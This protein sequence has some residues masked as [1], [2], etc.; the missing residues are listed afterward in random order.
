MSV[1]LRSSLIIALCAASASVGQAQDITLFDAEGFEW[2]LDSTGYGYVKDGG[3]T[4]GL[5]D[6]YDSWP[7]VCILTD[8]SDL[9]S[10]GSTEYYFVS[11]DAVQNG[12]EVIM[13]TDTVQ[14]LN[15]HRRAYV[16]DSGI[17]FL[18]YVDV[19][20]NPGAAPITFKV[21]VGTVQTFG[22]LGSDSSTQVT[23][24]SS[25]D[26]MLGTNDTWFTTDDFNT[27]GGDP[28]LGYVMR[29]NG[30]LNGVT[31]V[32]N[33]P[34]WISFSGSDDIVWEYE[35]VVLAPGDTVAYMYF[36]VQQ[37][38][39]ATAQARVSTIATGDPSYW[40]D[41]DPSIR[42]FIRNWALG[43]PALCGNNVVD[44]GEQ[45]DDGN[46][47]PTDAC[48]DFCLNAR[49]RDGRVQAGVEEC[50]DG[51]G[52]NDDA[53]SNMCTL[54]VC[55]DGIEQG[56]EECDLGMMNSD[57]EVDGCRTSCRF[58]FC[59]D[60][61]R[62]TGEGCDDGN[63]DDG[64]M[65]TNECVMATCGDGIVQSGIGEE[66]DDG[67]AFDRDACTAMCRTAVCG[68][69]I[70]RL[71][72]EE[73][74]DGNDVDGDG[75]S[76][77][78]TGSMCGNGRLDS[79]EQCDEGP[80]N[81]NTEP[82]ACRN[83][84]TSARCGDRVVDLGEECDDGNTDDGDSCTSTCSAPACG[85]GIVSTGELCDDGAENGMQIGK[86]NL[87]CDGFV[88]G[89]DGGGQGGLDM[90]VTMDMNTTRPDTGTISPDA[91]TPS[92]DDD[93]CSASGLPAAA[94]MWPMIGL[95]LARRRRRR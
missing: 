29:G 36:L 75:C 62:D 41:I 80:A 30:G 74:D 19:I 70:V 63:G 48:T 21:R 1:L 47:D 3:S 56:G 15:I 18:R 66:C 52:T 86:C 49:C 71:A 67:N 22:D 72:V 37:N 38:D 26:T 11:T 12:R 14:G 51:N 42:I 64:D 68:D 85:D 92:R 60:G 33:T 28:S 7:Y 9:T 58:F 81:S 24:T 55:G 65:C 25:G 23:S 5:S 35:S 13:A 89:F 77:T 88:R 20:T 79:G 59:G 17:G 91:G 84:C 6:A 46:N 83:D 87:T 94:A 31:L 32:T 53:C 39:A 95:L 16:P 57:T 76:N 27:S 82:G 50:D 10:C 34:P 78:C 4:S 44:L 8:P 40:Q 90:G 54:P 45:C 69:G 2:D 93:G 73:C 43:D 61:V